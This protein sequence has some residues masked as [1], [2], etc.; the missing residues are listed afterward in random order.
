MYIQLKPIL[1][2]VMFKATH[3]ISQCKGE[4]VHSLLVKLL[5]AMGMA[6]RNQYKIGHKT[7]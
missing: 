4:T 2:V 1:T 7:G 6:I 3:M 5:K